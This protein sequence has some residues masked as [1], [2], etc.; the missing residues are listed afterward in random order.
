M[1]GSA[2]LHLDWRPGQKGALGGRNNGVWEYIVGWALDVSFS[3]A[4]R[5][6]DVVDRN[7]VIIVFCTS[8]RI[9]EKPVTQDSPQVPHP[10]RH[11]NSLPVPDSP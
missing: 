11:A 6:M 7:W 10:T 1:L 9:F 3:T 5:F 2:S 4:T 8:R